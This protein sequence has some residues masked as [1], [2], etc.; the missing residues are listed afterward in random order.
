LK[1]PVAYTLMARRRNLSRFLCI[2]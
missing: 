1:K 2:Q